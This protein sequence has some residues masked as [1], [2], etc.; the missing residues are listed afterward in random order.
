[1]FDEFGKSIDVISMVT[2]DHTNACLT[3]YSITVGKHFYTQKP[4]VHS[5]YES[6]LLTKLA[7]KY[8]VATQMVNQDN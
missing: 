4:L 5:V 7:K 2:P 8:K 1:M 3:A 6:R